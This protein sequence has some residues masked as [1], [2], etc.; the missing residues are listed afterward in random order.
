MAKCSLRIELTEPDRVYQPGETVT[1]IVHV[2]VDSDVNCKGLEIK[3]GW[4]TN[5]KGNVSSGQAESITPFV[6]TWKTGDQ[7][8]YPFELSVADWPPTYHGTYLNIQ[9]A[10]DARAKIAWAFDPKAS[11]TYSMIPAGAP[12][13]VDVAPKA[14]QINGIFGCFIVGLIAMMVVV[15]LAFALTNPIVG[16]VL[17]VIAVV[18]G[19]IYF[20]KKVM[21]LL[22]LGK[23]DFE[24]T[25]TRVSPGESTTGTL[26]M[27]PRRGVQITAVT[28]ELRGREVCVSGSGSNRTTHTHELM[29]HTLTIAESV[30]IEPEQKTDLP[31]KIRIPDTDAYSCD[32]GD[33]KIVWTANFRIDIPRWP[34]YRESISLEVVPSGQVV[35][36]PPN[37]PHVET[38]PQPTSDPESGAG[39]ITFAETAGHFHA[40]RGDD[41]QAE[42]LADAVSGLTFPI[43]AF[44]E[45]RLLYSGDDDPHVYDDGYA[46][47]ARY[48]DPPLPMVLYVPHEMADDF[49]QAG[50]DLWQGRGTIVGWDSEH[51]RLQL[52]L[53]SG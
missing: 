10:I 27:M 53:L 41:D 8:A 6:G 40:L 7:E 3:S 43:E 25:S 22:V 42:A 49:E 19:G 28:V 24:L 17:F 26:Q 48:T 23:V 51:G 12:D 47:W 16:G 5:G 32:L 46:V 34:D 29:K 44:I 37:D 35:S 20:I 45:R 18:V 33:N 15:P 36:S 13:S 50:R 38:S 11:A 30:R 1:G 21:P 52:K 39:E 9:H 14:K 31:I 4:K 2:D